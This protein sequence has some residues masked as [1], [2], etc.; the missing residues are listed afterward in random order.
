MQH[1]EFAPPGVSVCKYDPPDAES[2]YERTNPNLVKISSIG[3]DSTSVAL[4]YVETVSDASSGNSDL[5]VHP[6][7]VKVLHKYANNFSYFCREFGDSNYG[8]IEWLGHIGAGGGLPRSS[9][10]NHYK[11]L[12]ISWYE[13]S[14]GNTSRPVD[15]RHEVQ[16]GDGTWRRSTHRRL[17]AVEAGLRKYFGYVLNRYIGRPEKGT[18]GPL[19][20]HKN[21]FH[22]DNGC[23]IG[24][25]VDRA[26]L[27]DPVLPTLRK[28][29]SCHYFI[30]DCVWAFTD[31]D[32][33]Y[34]GRWG[35]KTELGYLTLLRDM[36]MERLDP[37][38]YVSHYLL[39]LDFIIVHGLTDSRSGAYRWRDNPIEGGQ[40]KWPL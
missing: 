27:Q 9:F 30:Q 39:F 18:E 19:S 23:G 10:H 6:D 5:P 32:A 3:S 25:R 35:A 31:I 40:S 38:S 4:R 17:V 11:A 28:V 15:A 37:I 1:G 29:R 22:V 13:W 14:G 26:R 36:G 12:D 2:Y 16:T 24:L 8:R 34:D 21:H 20:P 33:G 7:L